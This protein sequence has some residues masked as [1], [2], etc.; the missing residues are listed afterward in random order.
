M[1]PEIVADPDRIANG[2]KTRQGFDSIA[3]I[4]RVNGHILLV[5][6]IKSPDKNKRLVVNSIR[7]IKP[8]YF[9]DTSTPELV[10]R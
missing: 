10:V 1:L 9:F 8:G 2:G 6:A 4:K 7:K 3:F 5:E